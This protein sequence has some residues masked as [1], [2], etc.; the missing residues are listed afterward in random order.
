MLLRFWEESQLLKAY[1]V[2]DDIPSLKII[3]FF[4][5]AYDMVEIVGTF[6]NPLL[7]LERFDADQP[8]LVFLDINMS[9]LSGMEAAERFIGM[10]PEADIVF[11]TAYD[12]FAVDAFELNATDYLVKPIIKARFDKCMDRL[13]RKR[14]GGGPGPEKKLAIGCFG[15]FRIYTHNEEPIRWRTEKSKELAALLIYNNGREVTRDEIIELLWPDTDLEKAVRYLH[16]S[17]YYIRKSLESY[18]IDRADIKITGSYAIIVGD[19]VQ[20]DYRTFIALNDYADKDTATLESIISLSGSDFMEGED[21]EWAVIERENVQTKCLDAVVKLTTILIRNK[22]YDRAESILKQAYA[23]N[24]YDE[25]LTTLLI[26]LYIG[27]NQKIKA[28]MHFNEYSELIKNELGIHPGK[29]IKE[30]I[31]SIK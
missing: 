28:M 16:N 31:N 5:K 19:N 8:Q 21:W 17:I 30:L 7:A 9:E 2:D 1:I 3:E 23:K 20:Y 29:F 24:P 18:N 6:T 4:L 14:N 15:K 22:E 10:N 12:D 26:K 25:R 11:T 13:L 27:A